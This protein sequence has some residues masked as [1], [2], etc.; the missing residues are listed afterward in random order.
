MLYMGGKCTSVLVHTG[1]LAAAAALILAVFYLGGADRA[2]TSLFY[3]AR[4][5]FFP[6]RD[7]WLLAVLGHTVLKW[8]VLGI[9]ALCLAF[10]GALRRGALYMAAIVLAV[11]V[12]K[13]YSPVS[14][15]WDL[16]EYGGKDPRAGRCLPAAHPLTGFSLFGLYLAL[17]ED[18]RRAARGVLAA[19]W[20][21]GLAAGAVQV[22]RGAHFASHVLWTAWVA[23]ALTLLLSRLPLPA[24]GERRRA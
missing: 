22:A 16:I 10:G 8:S 24:A 23:W 20:I 6:L 15:P 3:D 19:A 4:V 21:I 11:L 2:L 12:L 7:A 17:R 5:A 9:W 18:R 1:V 13:H 14:C